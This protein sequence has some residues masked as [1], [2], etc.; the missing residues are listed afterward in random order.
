MVWAYLFVCAASHGLLDAVTNGG[1]GVGF[2]IPFSAK[3]YFFEF[4]P[5]AV[6]TLSLD[7]FLNGQWIP[8]LRSE[9]MMIWAPAL[10][11]FLCFYIG[12]QTRIK[13]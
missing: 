8:V 6:S 4:R 3:R 12:T 7:K 10:V 13:A 1:L 5:I 11:L 2:F 9:L